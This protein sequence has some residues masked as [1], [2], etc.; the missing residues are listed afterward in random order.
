M[1][2]IGIPSL[3]PSHWTQ[4]ASTLRRSHRRDGPLEMTEV[5]IDDYRAAPNFELNL[6]TLPNLGMIGWYLWGKRKD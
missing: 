3:I 2:R 4:N 5:L 1:E 6:A